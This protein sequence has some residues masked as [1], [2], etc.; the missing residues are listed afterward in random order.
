MTWDVELRTPIDLTLG[1]NGLRRMVG[2]DW[3]RRR[4]PVDLDGLLLVYEELTSNGLR[5]GRS[6]VHVRTTATGR[7]W[8]VDVIDAAVEQPPV[9]AVDRDPADGGLGLHLVARLC[10]VRG[11][12]VEDDGK[13][14]W[15]CVQAA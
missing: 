11:W 14:V 10:R 7:G 4:A 9:P 2:T 5:H 3:L 1:R 12:T 15:A 13:H 8:F 6:P